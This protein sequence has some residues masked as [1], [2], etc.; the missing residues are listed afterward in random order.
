MRPSPTDTPTFDPI[1]S[2]LNPEPTITLIVTR[3]D[4]PLQETMTAANL[5]PGQSRLLAR[6]D[7]VRDRAD[8][9]KT[10]QPT[11]ISSRDAAR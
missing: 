9:A 1:G 5:S 11:A 8:S 3:P 10:A 2:I 7:G 4:T 6:P